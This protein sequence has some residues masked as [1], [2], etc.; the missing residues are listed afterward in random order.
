MGSA[1]TVAVVMGM[2]LAMSRG[3]D[4]PQVGRYQLG[5]GD[6]RLYKIDTVTGQVTLEAN[7]RVKFDR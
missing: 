6:G 7:P 1:A 3:T 5:A 4:G 2:C